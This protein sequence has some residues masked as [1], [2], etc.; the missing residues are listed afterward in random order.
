MI[1]IDPEAVYERSEL[2]TAFPDISAQALTRCLLAWGGKRPYASSR[3]VF[4]R[5]DA[6]LKA[7]EPDTGPLPASAEQEDP[8]RRPDRLA[9]IPRR[10]IR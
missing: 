4:I 6:L 1:K 7:L 5:G 10:S 3:K 9:M 8:P 2:A